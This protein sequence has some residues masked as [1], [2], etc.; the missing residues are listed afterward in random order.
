MHASKAQTWAATRLKAH[1]ADRQRRHLT[2]K[3]FIG[4]HSSTATPVRQ[5]KAR[6]MYVSLPHEGGRA[7][8]YELCQMHKA[9]A[10]PPS[11]RIPPVLTIAKS[12]LAP[13]RLIPNTEMAQALSPRLSSPIQTIRTGANLEKQDSEEVESQI[14]K[15][16]LDPCLTPWSARGVSRISFFRGFLPSAEVSPWAPTPTSETFSATISRQRPEVAPLSPLRRLA[17]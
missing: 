10:F 7:A 9:V 15:S 14:Q 1:A 13:L 4:C 6:C 12:P 11:L 16:N 2:Y 3:S 17:S 5:G 8:G